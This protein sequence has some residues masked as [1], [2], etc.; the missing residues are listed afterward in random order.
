MVGYANGLFGDVCSRKKFV[1]RSGTR[2]DVQLSG[3][4][5][6]LQQ[7]MYVCNLSECVFVYLLNIAKL[8]Q[9]RLK[10]LPIR[11]VLR[12]FEDT[13]ASIPL[14]RCDWYTITTWFVRARNP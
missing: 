7:T 1:G 3:Q 12:S 6:R 2:D 13:L 5:G 10:T 8:Q 9:T 14:L 4:S 11:L